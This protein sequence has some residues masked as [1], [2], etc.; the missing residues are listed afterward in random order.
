[1]TN[2]YKNKKNGNLYIYHGEIINATNKNDGQ[3]MILYGSMKEGKKFV[4][5][6]KEFFEKFEKLE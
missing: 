2:L 3:V 6:K 4:R 1:M 5:E